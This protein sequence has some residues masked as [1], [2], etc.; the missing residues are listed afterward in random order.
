MRI[1]TATRVISIQ[2]DFRISTA[3]RVIFIH[4]D[5]RIAIA[6]RVIFIHSDVRIATAIRVIFI[7][8][9]VRIATAF[10]VFIA[11][12][13]AQIIDVVHLDILKIVFSHGESRYVQFFGWLKV[14]IC[15]EQINRVFGHF[16]IG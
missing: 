8:S 16:K 2:C 1:G 4:S 5:V 13:T 11:I 12:R 7:H 10:F 3:I 15:R 9:D 6:I 14:M